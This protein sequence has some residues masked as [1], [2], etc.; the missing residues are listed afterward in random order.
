M[1]AGHL[2]MFWRR[3]SFT[4]VKPSGPTTL[5]ISANSVKTHLQRGMRALA[6]TLEEK[7]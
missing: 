1:C 3:S 7:R 4:L 5:G 2:S 6:T